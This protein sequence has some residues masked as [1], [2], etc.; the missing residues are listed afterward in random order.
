MHAEHTAKFNAN[1]SF[2]QYRIDQGQP[3][4]P[5]ALK[6]DCIFG[7]RTRTAV[8][9]FQQLMFP[10]QIDHHT[11]IVGS[12]T[13]AHLDTLS[14]GSDG[15]A[16]VAVAWYRLAGPDGPLNWD[17]IIGLD[18]FEIDV[19]F[20]AGGLPIPTMPPTVTV[21]ITARQP[22]RIPIIGPPRHAGHPRSGRDRPA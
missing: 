11:G 18:V 6:T 3:G 15:A 1:S 22:N 4:L 20:T 19:E 17:N 21:M 16:Q 13:W 8:T 2:F 10:G 5:N 7:T 14:I 9:A 12:K